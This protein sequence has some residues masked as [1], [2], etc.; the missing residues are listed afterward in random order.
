VNEEIGKPFYRTLH[1]QNGRLIISGYLKDGEILNAVSTKKGK[2]GWE[3]TSC[4]TG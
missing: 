3:L 4:K 2:K 1:L